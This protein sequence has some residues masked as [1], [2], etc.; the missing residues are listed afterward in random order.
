M[1]VRDIAGI[2]KRVSWKRRVSSILECNS[3]MSKIFLLRTWV[4]GSQSGR[5]VPPYF[6]NSFYLL[7]IYLERKYVR[8]FT[9]Q[10]E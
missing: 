6:K 7:G 8:T 2:I 1:G 10:E 3:R 5:V 4:V 9:M